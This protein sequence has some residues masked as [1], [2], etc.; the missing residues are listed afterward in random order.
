MH[1]EKEIASQRNGKGKAEINNIPIH[2][3]NEGEEE[4]EVR[5]MWM[6]AEGSYCIYL[7]KEYVAR[8]SSK[9]N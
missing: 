3:L 6:E 1:V 8:S 7:G 5:L 9:R 4:R 2:G